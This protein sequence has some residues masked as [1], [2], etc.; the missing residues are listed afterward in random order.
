MYVKNIL[1]QT[2]FIDAAKTLNHVDKNI[3]KLNINIKFTLN[4]KILVIACPSRNK[5]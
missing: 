2:N 4:T 1:R 5:L 3:R